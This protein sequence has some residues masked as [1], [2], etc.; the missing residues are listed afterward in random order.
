MTTYNTIL[1]YGN[2]FISLVIEVLYIA[3]EPLLFIE[4]IENM[5]LISYIGEMERMR[6]ETND[7]PFH[8]S[9]LIN[10]D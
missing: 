7:F 10:S 3:I 1:K 6:N 8:L 2:I 5:N 4:L 9:N